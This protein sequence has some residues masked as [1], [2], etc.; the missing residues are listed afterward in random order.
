M[1]WAG[2]W[3]AG[4]GPT[5]SLQVEGRRGPASSFPL[6]VFK[7]KLHEAS[8][9]RADQAAQVC[10]ADRAAQVCRAD[11]VAPCP[12][13]TGRSSFSVEGGRAI[14]DRW[15]GDRKGQSGG[16]GPLQCRGGGVVDPGPTC[17]TPLWSAVG[18]DA[19]ARVP[20]C[21]TLPNS[22]VKGDG[23]CLQFTDGQT[24]A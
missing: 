7:L 4:E 23:H 16:L 3:E 6:A 22:P 11:R 19:K 14:S 2:S 13:L 5:L 1:P 9:C 10:R 21:V 15:C 17:T 24:E 20:R 8:V 18:D 12:L